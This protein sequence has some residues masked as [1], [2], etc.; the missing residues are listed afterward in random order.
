MCGR[1]DCYTDEEFWE[2]NPYPDHP[3]NDAYD[4]GDTPYLQDEDGMWY[5]Y[6]YGIFEKRDSEDPKLL[7]DDVITVYGEISE[8][9][10][11][12]S[13]IVNSEE[14]F[15]IDMKYVDLISE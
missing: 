3:D 5:G 2:Q 13:F 11:T 12:Q 1:K 7:E 8:P 9:R 14:L 6:E 15:C 4:I 10:E